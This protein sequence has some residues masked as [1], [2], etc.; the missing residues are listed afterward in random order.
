[1]KYTYEELEQ[2]VASLAVKVKK[3]EEQVEG[4]IT[5]VTYINFPVTTDKDL[6]KK[7]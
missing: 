2:L 3:L 5:D 7:G 1:M 6:D 4:L